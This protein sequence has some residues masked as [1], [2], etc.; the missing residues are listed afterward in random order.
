MLIL[1]IKCDKSLNVIFVQ[2]MTILS[3]YQV[4]TLQSYKYISYMRCFLIL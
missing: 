4:L 3:L 1:I 2:G